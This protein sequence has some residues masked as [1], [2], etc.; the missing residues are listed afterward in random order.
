DFPIVYMRPSDGSRLLDW[1]E[2]GLGGAVR[3]LS[4]VRI[5]PW[6][7]DEPWSPSASVAPLEDSELHWLIP[8]GLCA[9]FHQSG[10]HKK[11]FR[12][13][14]VALSAA[15]VDCVPGLNLRPRGTEPSGA[16]ATPGAF[17]HE[18]ETVLLY[19]DTE[20]DWLVALAGPLTAIVDRS[21]V[22]K[23]L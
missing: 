6:R 16:S 13:A 22:L 12:E 21:D 17:W 2:E 23:D 18:D 15:Q 14:L 1:L 11:G 9:A 8:F 4:L 3:Q 7:G 19:D 5:D 10:V 20:R